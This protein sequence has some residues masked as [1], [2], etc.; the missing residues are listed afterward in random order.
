MTNEVIKLAKA[1]IK[2]NNAV[3]GRHR[4]QVVFQVLVSLDSVCLLEEDKRGGPS[5]CG[6]ADVVE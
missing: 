3:S 6:E 1:R 5:I 2:Q 4:N